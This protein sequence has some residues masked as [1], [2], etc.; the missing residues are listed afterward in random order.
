MK[1]VKIE[2][3]D[4]FTLAGLSFFGDPFHTY[5]GWTESNEIG[6]LWKRLMDFTNE[7]LPIMY[8]VHIQNR[9]TAIT[10]EFEVFVGYEIRDLHETPYDLCL[11]ILP[12]SLYA[13]FTI[14][15]TDL[16]QDESIVDQWLETN[17]YEVRHPYFTQRFDQRF[18]GIEQLN[19]SEL[20][21]LVPITLVGS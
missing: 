13:V 10:G 6:R 15:G 8:E 3:F 19:I 12:A 11:K 1:S 7:V 18:K 2:Q 20:D 14:K 4:T 5:A 17:G 16:H 21:F 9:D